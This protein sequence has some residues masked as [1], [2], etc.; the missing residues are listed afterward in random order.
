MRLIA[1]VF[2]FLIGWNG[3]PAQDST[4]VDSAAFISMLNRIL[5]KNNNRKILL[6]EKPARHE[7]NARNY[8]IVCNDTAFRWAQPMVKQDSILI[9]PGDSIGGNDFFISVSFPAYSSDGK[10]CAV[11]VSNM[12]GEWGGAGQVYF[13]SK[14]RKKWKLDKIRT[15]WVS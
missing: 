6:M 2:V 13:F 11:Y 5:P 8:S 1:C 14:K 3:L 10:N 12:Q 9:V 7:W 15:V 4:A